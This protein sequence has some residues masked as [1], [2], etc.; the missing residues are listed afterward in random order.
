V[1]ISNG[2]ATLAQ[3]K[4]ALRIASGDATDDALLEMAVESAS[5]L[6]DAYC[7]RNFIN[8]GTA[9][10]YYNT[11]NPYVVQIDDA[12]SI[13]QVQ[14]STG[15]DGVYDTTWT[16]GTAGGEGDAQPEPIND[17]LGGVVWPY[18]RIRAIGDYSF[19][20]G[21]ENSIKVTAVFGWPNIP[22]T[23]TQATI[24]QSSRIFA[25]L[26]S[27]LGVAG[28]GPDMGVMR[29]SRGLDPDVVQLVEGYR[30]VNGVA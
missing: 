22:V 16:I 27:P 25:R 20:T 12:R 10:R 2:Y 18:T 24:L 17:Y 9:T 23:V 30:R 28:F 14:T 15:L 21:P 5:R 11:D 4:S 26:Q 13:S 3:I 29:V 6:I 7:G 8:A 1:A 19:P